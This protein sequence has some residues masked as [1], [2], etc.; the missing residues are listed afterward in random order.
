[1]NVP[2]GTH[3]LFYGKFKITTTKEDS[4]FFL[5][6]GR[7]SLVKSFLFQIL[8]SVAKGPCPVLTR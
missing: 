1:M 5:K 4:R 8:Q 3:T 2:T 6:V 7:K